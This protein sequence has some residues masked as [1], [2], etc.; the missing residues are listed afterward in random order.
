MLFQGPATGTTVRSWIVHFHRVHSTGYAIAPSYGIKDLVPQTVVEKCDHAEIGASTGLHRCLSRPAA[1]AAVCC[2]I[3]RFK[4][5]ICATCAY[6][7][8]SGDINNS[9]R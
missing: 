9:I 7:R 8:A 5:R 4:R 6:D 3:E 2:W 1:S